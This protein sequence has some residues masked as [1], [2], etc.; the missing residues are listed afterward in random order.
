MLTDDQLLQLAG[1]GAFERGLGY[2]RDDRVK[3]ECF[4]VKLTAG[5][6]RGTHRPSTVEDHFQ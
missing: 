1:K 5:I 3:L 2:H 6:A 4:D